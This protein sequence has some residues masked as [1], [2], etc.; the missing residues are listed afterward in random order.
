M[1][2]EKILFETKVALDEKNF[3]TLLSIT[4]KNL[5]FQKEKG[6]FKVKYRV[7]KKIPF[8]TLKIVNDQVKILSKFNKI[9]LY[10]KDDELYYFTVQ[11]MFIERKVID[12]INRN[13]L[14][15]NFI[16]RT[17]KKGIKGLKII[18]KTAFV[19][20]GV[21]TTVGVTIT[22]LSKSKDAVKGAA[23]AVKTFIKR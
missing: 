12:I 19:V 7:V 13:T 11:N 17:S 15:E 5:Y 3:N 16:E 8:D 9:G 10:N 22:A 4:D 1:N 21:A 23:K 18:Q 6:I 20:A 14:G 2:N